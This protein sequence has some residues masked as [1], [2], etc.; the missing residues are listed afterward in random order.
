MTKVSPC[1]GHQINAAAHAD[2]TLGGAA[3]RSSRWCFG[4]VRS[5]SPKQPDQR[6]AAPATPRP[7]IGM[8]ARFAVNAVVRV[9]ALLRHARLLRAEDQQILEAVMQALAD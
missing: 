5:Q 1:D 6:L 4:G 8:T 3:Y 9:A 2:D 7:V